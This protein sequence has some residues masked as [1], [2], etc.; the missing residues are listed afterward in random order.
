MSDW[1]HWDDIMDAIG[2]WGGEQR[3]HFDEAIQRIAK[4]QKENANL[5]YTELGEVDGL[6]PCPFCGGKCEFVKN[7][8]GLYSVMCLNDDRHALDWW[9]VE[10]EGAISV[11]NKRV[12]LP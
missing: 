8:D 7:K 1:V 10:K 12:N 11:W 6:K 5:T 2:N 3:E 4:V 9:C